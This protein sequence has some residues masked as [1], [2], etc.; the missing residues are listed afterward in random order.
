[1]MAAKGF[2]KRYPYNF[3]S[4]S[5]WFWWSK[6]HSLLM[7]RHLQTHKHGHLVP[8]TRMVTFWGLV[9]WGPSHHDLKCHN[10]KTSI[11]AQLLT[12]CK[13]HILSCMC[14]NFFVKRT[15][16]KFHLKFWTHIQQ[17]H[18]C[19]WFTISLN[20]DVMSFYMYMMHRSIL[21]W[22]VNNIYIYIVLVRWAPA[23]INLRAWTLNH[24]HSWTRV[25]S[26]MVFG[27]L[28]LNTYL[29]T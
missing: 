13:M 23:H 9:A 29:L 4:S 17:N 10:F 27:L 26:P 14:S 19:V 11:F 20:C 25:W 15:P 1:M 6:V 18:F 2:C 21:T 7:D 24:Q 5:F 28:D 3:F 16:L 8:G 22:S 12:P